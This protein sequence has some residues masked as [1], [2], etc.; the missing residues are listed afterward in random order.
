MPLTDRYGRRI[1]YLRLSITDRC[2]MRCRYCMPEEGVAKL[3][4]REVLSYEDLLLLAQAAVATGI[5]K[6]RVTGG[7]PLVRKGLVGFLRQLSAIPGLRHLVLTTNGQLL[8]EMA[9][10][11]KQAGVQRLNISL[12]SLRPDVFAQITRRGDLA[13]VLDGIAAAERAGLP[14]KLNMVV[15]RGVN[16]GEIADFAALTLK[17]NCSVRFIE[18]MPAIQDRNWQELVVP[19]E[20]ILANLARD[21]EFA[22]IIRGELAG[23]AREYRISGARGNIGVITALSG[24][25]CRDCNRVRITA[26]GKVR[27]CLFADAEHDLRPL[28]ASGDAEALQAEL[29]R[30][31]DAKPAQHALN[32]Q[33]AGHVPFAMAQ[34]G[35]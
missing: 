19:G 6:I 9:E 11:L 5:E 32:S 1:N 14:V 21:Y 12:D 35:G 18:Y 3:D 13:R 15:M 2:D 7:E 8:A 10:E 28:L 16:D 27:T 17:K 26:S 29:R 30:L 22:P 31:V 33:D 23:P 24:H 4:H 25:F 20:E 34:I